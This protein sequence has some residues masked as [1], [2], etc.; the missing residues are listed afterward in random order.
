MSILVFVEQGQKNAQYVER[1]LFCLISSS[2]KSTVLE[3]KIICFRDLKRVASKKKKKHIKPNRKKRQGDAE[4]SSYSSRREKTRKLN[5]RSCT[6]LRNERQNLQLRLRKLLKREMMSSWRN[7]R[8]NRMNSW[9][10]NSKNSFLPKT[11]PKIIVA[12]G[13]RSRSLRIHLTTTMTMINTKMMMPTITTKMIMT[14][15]REIKKKLR[16]LIKSMPKTTTHPLK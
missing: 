10:K 8:W 12:L 3:Q 6:S 15:T 14:N 13:W 7:Y 4:K 9:L 11:S 1:V 2:I 16:R 5:W